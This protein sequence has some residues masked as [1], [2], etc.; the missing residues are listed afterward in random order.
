MFNVFRSVCFYCPNLDIRW[1]AVLVFFFSGW[2]EPLL[3]LRAR[4]VFV[5]TVLSDEPKQNKGRGLDDSK[6]VNPPPHTQSNF[7]AGRP[8]AAL[9]FW[10]FGGFRIGVPLS[11]IILVIYKY[12]NR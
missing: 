9:I 1:S 10:F 12:N 6:L 4:F 8:K 11:I 3:K 7:I 5:V 2:D